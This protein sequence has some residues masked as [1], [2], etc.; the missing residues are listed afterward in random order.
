[1]TIRDRVLIRDK[2]AG[3]VVVGGQDNVQAVAGQ[4]L[5]FFAGLGFPLPQCS[6]VAHSRGWA[7]E[8]MERNIA[9]LRT[10]R[11]LRGGRVGPLAL[12][13]GPRGANS[14]PFTGV[15]ACECS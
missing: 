5:G 11:E 10:N 2:V 3:F 6:Y 8:D 12:P 1:V 9:V 14:H 13:Q 4:I 15:N 7:A